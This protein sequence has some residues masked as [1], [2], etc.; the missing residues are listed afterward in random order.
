LG[1]LD[2]NLSQKPR[3]EKSKC[4][5]VNLGCS[6]FVENTK[7]FDKINFIFGTYTPKSLTALFE[8][9]W[10]LKLSCSKAECNLPFSEEI[11]KILKG[12][13]FKLVMGQNV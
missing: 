6:F 2:K 11:I 3:H 12:G 7:I 8:I 4:Q 13:F 10:F 5:T 9:C 1:V